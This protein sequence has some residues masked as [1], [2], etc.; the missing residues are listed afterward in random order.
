MVNVYSFGAFS[1]QSPLLGLRREILLKVQRS[2]RVMSPRWNRRDVLKGL[3]ASSS[4]VFI[5]KQAKAS[6]QPSEPQVEVQI[7]PVSTYTF[8]LSILPVN[9][10]SVGDIPMDGSLVKKSWGSPIAK[11]QAVPNPH[12][13]PAGARRRSFVHPLGSVDAAPQGDVVRQCY[14]DQC[15]ATSHWC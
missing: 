8:R 12:L 14:H 13:S 11:L 10:R 2:T 5:P 15:P 4:A 6:V 9:N 1:L 7:T 3:L